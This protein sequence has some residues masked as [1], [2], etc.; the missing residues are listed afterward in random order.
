M[1]RSDIAEKNRDRNYK[2][3]LIIAV[4]IGLSQGDFEKRWFEGE[5]RRVRGVSIGRISLPGLGL[6]G[7]VGMWDN[8]FGIYI[9]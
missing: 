1:V 9:V 2:W 7:E 8:C 5:V 4:G 3:K 6:L